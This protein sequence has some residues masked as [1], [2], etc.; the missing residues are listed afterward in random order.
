MTEIIDIEEF[1]KMKKP[2]PKKRRYRIRVDRQKYV[3]DK[4]CLTGKE[5]LILAGKE[6]YTRFQLNQRCKGSV[7]KID[8]DEKVD[9]TQRGVERF[10][11]LPLDQTEG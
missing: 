11:T 10:M 8:Y 1:V 5:I 7:S 2:I 4:E 3:T 9:F 6:P